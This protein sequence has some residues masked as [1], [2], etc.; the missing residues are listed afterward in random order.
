[1]TALARWAQHLS[2]EHQTTFIIFLKDSRFPHLQA[3][4]N[5]Q[6]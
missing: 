2:Q 4:D 1:L 6:E 3:D 5:L